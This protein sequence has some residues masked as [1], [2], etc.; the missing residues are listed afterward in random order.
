MILAGLCACACVWVRARKEMDATRH[1]PEHAGT[2][3]LPKVE[4]EG[5]RRPKR[6][7]NAHSHAY[8]FPPCWFSHPSP[9]KH[10]PLGG[11]VQPPQPCLPRPTAFLLAPPQDGSEDDQIPDP[12]ETGWAVYQDSDDDLRQ[13]PILV[14]D[15][16]EQTEKVRQRVDWTACVR[17][18]GPRPPS[19]MN[20]AEVHARTHFPR[21]TPQSYVQTLDGRVE[22]FWIVWDGVFTKKRAAERYLRQLKKSKLVCVVWH[23]LPPPISTLSPPHGIH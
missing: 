13:V 18:T 6:A 3:G 22:Q 20:R 8:R 11:P 1:V 9:L 10:A 7:K 21:P 14:T 15:L 16:N 19:G 17:R 12:G 23:S 5:E 2:W 4:P